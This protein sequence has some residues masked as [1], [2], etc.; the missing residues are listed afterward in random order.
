MTC[1]RTSTQRTGATMSVRLR[2]ERN[3]SNANATWNL[4]ENDAF[5]STPLPTNVNSSDSSSLLL[6]TILKPK[7]AVAIKRIKHKSYRKKYSYTLRRMLQTDLQM[8]FDIPPKRSR[9][10]SILSASTNASATYSETIGN[11]ADENAIRETNSLHAEFSEDIEVLLKSLQSTEFVGTV[12]P[13]Y[14][15]RYMSEESLT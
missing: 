8:A 3:R 13:Q 4:A 6:S 9:P 7:V 14:H 12:D 11:N 1:T 15:S 10:S 2:G 5:P